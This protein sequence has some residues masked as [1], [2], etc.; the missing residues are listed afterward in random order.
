MLFPWPHRAERTAAVNAAAAEKDRS[1]RDAAAAA[2]LE[3][4]IRT[5]AQENH[6]AEV[7]ASQIITRHRKGT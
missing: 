4:Q 2:K 7:L 5:M 1:C 3:R 6:F